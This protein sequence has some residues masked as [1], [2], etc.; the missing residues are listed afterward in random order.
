MVVRF[1]LGGRRAVLDPVGR[2]SSEP[3]T[4]LFHTLCEVVDRLDPFCALADA[5]HGFEYASE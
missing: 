5:T 4:R 3:D 1:Q 2:E